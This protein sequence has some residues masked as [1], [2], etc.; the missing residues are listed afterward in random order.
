[1]N[2]FQTTTSNMTNSI[3]A[4]FGTFVTSVTAILA[5]IA[6]AIINVFYSF[7]A[8]G[9]AVLSGVMQFGQSVL[10]REPQPS[11]SLSFCSSKLL[12]SASTSSKAC[13]VS[14]QVCRH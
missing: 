13:L 14:W 8:L 11:L 6:N 10:K 9:Q 3:A 1:M 7:L 4:S 5:S 2:S 12:Q